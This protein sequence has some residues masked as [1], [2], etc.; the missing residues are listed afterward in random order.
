[1]FLIFFFLNAKKINL[2]LNPNTFL[3]L[4]PLSTRQTD[5]SNFF[6]IV[7]TRVS[8]LI[9]ALLSSFALGRK[10]KNYSTERERDRDDDDVRDHEF[11]FFFFFFNDDENTKRK[12]KWKK[13][14]HFTEEAMEQQQKQ[15][16]QR[17]DDKGFF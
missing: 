12:Y 10:K 13:D 8:S 3:C 16:K 17:N 9:T 6:F 14:Y 2:G 5:G 7:D 11:V 15:Q 1:M 4:S